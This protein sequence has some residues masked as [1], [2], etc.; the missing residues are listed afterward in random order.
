VSG[1]SIVWTLEELTRAHRD[2]L[3]ALFAERD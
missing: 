3:P 1:S 2:A